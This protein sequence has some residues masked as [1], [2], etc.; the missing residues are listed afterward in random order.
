VSLASDIFDTVRSF[1]HTMDSHSPGAEVARGKITALAV[2]AIE[3]QLEPITEEL[4]ALREEIRIKNQL[5]TACQETVEN[6]NRMIE[7]LPK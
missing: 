1:A 6:L 3:K 4:K 2:A 5:L 7:L